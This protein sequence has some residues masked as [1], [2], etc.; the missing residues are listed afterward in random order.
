M[1]PLK[2]TDSWGADGLAV[3]VPVDPRRRIGTPLRGTRGTASRAAPGPKVPLSHLLRT[4]YGSGPIFRGL[5]PNF[6]GVSAPPWG[7]PLGLDCYG[8]RTGERPP[9]QL[10]AARGGRNWVNRSVF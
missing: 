10:T 5:R 2:G 6:P 8:L 4:G 9:L 7:G 1:S 3:P